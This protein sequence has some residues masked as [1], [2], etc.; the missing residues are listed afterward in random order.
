MLATTKKI[1]LFCAVAAAVNIVIGVLL[2]L[3]FQT[4]KLGFAVV[5]CLS[6]YLITTSGILLGIT[7]ALRSTCT[8]INLDNESITKDI[9]SLRKRVQELEKRT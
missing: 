1:S 8:D 2:L 5:F 9:V 3:Y 6:V 4:L 7:C